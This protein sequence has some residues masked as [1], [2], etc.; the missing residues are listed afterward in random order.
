VSGK[1]QG[2]SCRSARSRPRRGHGLLLAHDRPAAGCGSAR[3]PHL[4]RRPKLNGTLRALVPGRS[5][6]ARI[7]VLPAFVEAANH[8]AQAGELVDVLRIAHTKLD[9]SSPAPLFPATVA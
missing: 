3:I 7:S 4:A 1:N 9:P 8:Q 6:G 5:G 2:P